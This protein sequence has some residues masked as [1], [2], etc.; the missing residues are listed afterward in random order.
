MAGGQDNIK[1]NDMSQTFRHNNIIEYHPYIKLD[2]DLPL[3]V[4]SIKSLVV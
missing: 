2:N 1:S 3:F 4:I